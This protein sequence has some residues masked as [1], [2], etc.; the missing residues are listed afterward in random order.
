MCT[1]MNL[2]NIHHYFGRN[3]DIEKS[4]NERIIITPRRFNLNLKSGTQIETQYAIIGIGCLKNDY[5]LYFDAC[6]EKGLG[7]AGLR[8]TKAF[9]PE[10]DSDKTNI[11]TFEL[12]P[13]ILGTCKNTYEAIDA[14]KTMCICNT[15]FDESL[16]PA[17]LHWFISDKN[18]SV[19]L[20]CEK[21]GIRIY[22]N[23]LGVLTNMPDFKSHIYNLSN[24]RNLTSEACNNAFLP[25]VELKEYSYGTGAFGLPGDMSS[26]SRFVR[27][28]YFKFNTQSIGREVSDDITRFFHILSG[29]SQFYGCTTTE[30]NKKEFTLYSSCCDTETSTYYYTTYTNARISAVKLK[31]EDCN[32]E[33]LKIIPLKFLQD[34]DEVDINSPIANY[35]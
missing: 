32:A 17:P 2:T 15:A 22:D 34:I 9:Y 33:S 12:I 13:Y 18:K 6:N 19:T 24:Y 7:I 16:K 1:A 35:R 23:V 10:P 21:G 30:S 20:E 28:A 27:A 4:Y 11:A 25:S 5:P 29:V 8:Y 3:L 26:M 31:A 14:I